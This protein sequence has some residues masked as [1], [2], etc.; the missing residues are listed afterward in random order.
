[1]ASITELKQIAENDEVSVAIPIFQRNGDP[2]LGADGKQSTISV[3]GSESPA[4]RRARKSILKRM[5]KGSVDMDT[6]RVEMAA[7]AV[8]N[9]SGWEDGD[10]SLPFSPENVKVLLKPEHILSQVEA[11]IGRYA[12]FSE[13]DA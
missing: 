6:M 5:T 11:G 7:L 13:S 12:V 3:V 8:T 4:Y 2:Y 1:M 10:K 9:W